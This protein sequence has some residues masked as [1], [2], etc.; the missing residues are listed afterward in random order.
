MPQARVHLLPIIE[1][2]VR[3]TLGYQSIDLSS[4]PV[5]VQLLMK[6]TNRHIAKF[7]FQE[8]VALLAD[9]FTRFAPLS[10]INCD[11]SMFID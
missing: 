3:L 5:P 9:P 7:Q 1:K 11:T 2:P 6:L 8:F 4:L 10:P